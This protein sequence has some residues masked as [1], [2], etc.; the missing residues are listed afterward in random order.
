MA[1]SL[2]VLLSPMLWFGQLNDQM[3]AFRKKELKHSAISKISSVFHVFIFSQQL[4]CSA[5]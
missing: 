5:T 4:P 3:H 1:K 2:S